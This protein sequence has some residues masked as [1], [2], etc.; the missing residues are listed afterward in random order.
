MAGKLASSVVCEDGTCNAANLLVRG[1]KISF[2]SL[3]QVAKVGE[4]EL[5]EKKMPSDL[6]LP[7]GHVLVHDTTGVA[8]DRCDLYV[9][10]WHTKTTNKAHRLNPAPSEEELEA[11]RTYFGS[12]GRFMRGA[13]DIPKGPWQLHSQVRFIR[14]QRV[15]THSGSYEHKYEVPVDLLYCKR[16]LAWRLPLPSGCVVDARGFV[17]P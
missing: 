12:D 14:Y 13:V 3:E 1:D 10:K 6:W 17:Y 15:G 4:Y 8:L 16:P 7:R 5:D 2:V 9:V 11:A